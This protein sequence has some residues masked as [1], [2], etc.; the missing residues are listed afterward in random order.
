MGL[1]IKNLEVER[2][3]NEIS[4]AT[5]ESKTEAIRVA[6]LQRKERL[7]L[8]SVGERWSRIK[9]SLEREVWSKLPPGVIGKGIPQAEQDDVLG[10]GPDGC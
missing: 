1:N 8:P 5:G 3:A 10:F 6:L 9:E 4:M 2:L 7:A